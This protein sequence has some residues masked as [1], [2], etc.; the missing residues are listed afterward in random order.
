MFV[1]VQKPQCYQ[2]IPSL[3]LSKACPILHYLLIGLNIILQSGLIVSLLIY[4]TRAYLVS[5]TNFKSFCIWKHSSLLS[6]PS[7]YNNFDLSKLNNL[8]Y[9]LTFICQFVSVGGPIHNWLCPLGILVWWTV[10]T[11]VG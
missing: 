8:I 3:N 1:F 4:N 10:P 2:H 11:C 7:G 9:F 6:L 5:S